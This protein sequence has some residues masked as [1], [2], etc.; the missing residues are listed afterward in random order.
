M[1]RHNAT[2]QDTPA[3]DGPEASRETVLDVMLD[4]L[5][6]LVVDHLVDIETRKAPVAGDCRD[7]GAKTGTRIREKDGSDNGGG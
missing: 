6:E 7:R 4:R 3:P 2:N 1:A 5:A